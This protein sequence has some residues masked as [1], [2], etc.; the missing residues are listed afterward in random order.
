MSHPMV[1][2]IEFQLHEIRMQLELINAKIELA[3]D[4]G[5]VR[6]LVTRRRYL[7]VKYKNYLRK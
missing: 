7:S 1:N 5:Q 4:Y 3:N 2:T 6:D